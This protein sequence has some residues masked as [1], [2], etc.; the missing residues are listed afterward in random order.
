MTLQMSVTGLIV[1][2]LYFTVRVLPNFDVLVTAPF[3]EATRA[4]GAA[5]TALLYV[6]HAA[7]R[8]LTSKG[9]MGIVRGEVPPR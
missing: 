5:P 3:A 8:G 6:T 2:S 7:S 4:Y 9:M 1:W